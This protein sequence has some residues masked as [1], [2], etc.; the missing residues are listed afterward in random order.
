M[1]AV[2][3]AASAAAIDWDAGEPQ[4]F[5]S[6]P[7]LKRIDALGVRLGMP[8]ADAEAILARRGM[9]REQAAGV[10][11]PADRSFGAL[12]YSTGQGLP[13]VDVT[14][15]RVRGRSVVT[16]LW[17]QEDFAFTSEAEKDRLITTRYGDP[18]YI[19]RHSYGSHYHW[20]DRG[21]PRDR[22]QLEATRSCLSVFSTCVEPGVPRDCPANLIR[23]G[24]VMSASFGRGARNGSRLYLSL[25]DSASQFETLYRGRHRLP[26]RPVCSPPIAN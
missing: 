10:S 25:W 22:Q 15:H 2:T 18:T 24:T 20:T 16:G 23:R 13:L 3:G 17:L 21:W 11:L 5:Y 12:R 8:L 1:G 19:D 7:Q 4:R 9:V 6:A 14:H 26:I